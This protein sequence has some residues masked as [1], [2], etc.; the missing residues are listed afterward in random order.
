MKW[1]V[2][3][4]C[5]LAS[6]VHA[7]TIGCA[8]NPHDTQMA[9][10][11]EDGSMAVNVVNPNGYEYMP[12][13]DRAAAAQ[14]P[15]M[16][17]Q[18][19]GLMALS[20]YFEYRWDLS[21]CVFDSKDPWLMECHGSTGAEGPDNDIMALG[22]STAK[23]VETSVN[24]TQS[25]YRLRLFFEKGNTYFVTIPFPMSSCAETEMIAKSIKR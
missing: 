16:K 7:K 10:I 23:I 5:L 2:L 20:Y 8:P 3:A 18:A 6:S 1:I 12:Q 13:F 22:F 9:L 4:L 14:I 15:Y 24:G 19:E 11:N 25:T 17:V 21:K